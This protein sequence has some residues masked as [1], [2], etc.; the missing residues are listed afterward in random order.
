MALKA[1][2]SAELAWTAVIAIA[3]IVIGTVTYRTKKETPG[4]PRQVI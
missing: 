2:T 1:V 4:V 3:K